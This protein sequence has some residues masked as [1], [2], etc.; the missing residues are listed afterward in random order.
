MEDAFRLR[1]QVYC[2]EKGFLPADEYPSGC[3]IDEFD[4]SA[5]HLLVRGAD[6]S[7]IGYMRII[8]GRGDTGFPMFAHG[9]TVH[10]DFAIPEPG[11][12]VEISR[13]IVRSDFR[14]EIRS[15][16]EG[17]VHSPGLPSPAARNA[18]DLVQLKLLR[19]TYHH[20]LRKDARW[21]YAAMEPTLHRKFRMMGI[22]FGPIGPPA[23]YFGEVRPYAMNLRTLEAT[24]EERFPETMEFFDS[25]C[26]DLDVSVLRP[27]EWKMPS[28]SLAA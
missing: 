11:D 17:F 15:A 6:S 22:P 8:D 23:D 2:K 12:A 7:L 5:T 13:M 19:E 9:M 25:P 28:I 24:L 26:Q 18:S 16:H 1:F 14:H 10:D 4:G 21:V 3:E 27:N 20:A